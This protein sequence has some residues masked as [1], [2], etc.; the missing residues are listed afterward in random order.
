MF[1]S[2]YPNFNTDHTVGAM[3]DNIMY[4][5]TCAMNECTDGTPM[6][7]TPEDVD[8]HFGLAYKFKKLGLLP[9]ENALLHAIVL[10]RPGGC[11]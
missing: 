2:V 6:K 10:M 11:P 5:R 3:C 4:C 1:A 8:T 7:L 9:T